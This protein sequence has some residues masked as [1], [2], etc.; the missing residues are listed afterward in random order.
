MRDGQNQSSPNAAIPEAVVAG[1]L[2]IQ[3]GV[4]NYC[5]GERIESP[6]IG[7]DLRK[8]STEDI[9]MTHRLMFGASL[10]ALIILL[11]VRECVIWMV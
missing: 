11:T 6:Y 10:A 5:Q 1:A 9:A 3:L 4:V 7:I 8:L 2:G